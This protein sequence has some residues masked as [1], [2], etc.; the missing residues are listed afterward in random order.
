M[1]YI[2]LPLSVA[3]LLWTTKDPVQ[4]LELSSEQ[5]HPLYLFFRLCLDKHKVA[6]YKARFFAHL[7]MG[8]D[9]ASRRS[10]IY[11]W[12]YLDTTIDPHIRTCTCCLVQYDNTYFVKICIYVIITWRIHTCCLE[13]S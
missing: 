9:Q 2:S 11:A 13:E 6:K 10:G 5:W 1:Y 3:G 8:H 7:V 4:I 12:E